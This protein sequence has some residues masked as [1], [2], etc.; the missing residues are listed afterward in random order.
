MPRDGV[1]EMNA[2]LDVALG[3]AR[4]G[5]RVVPVE[6]GGKKPFNP[7]KAGGVGWQHLRGT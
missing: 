1:D 4:R 6:R 2:A 5:W 7:D 3:Y